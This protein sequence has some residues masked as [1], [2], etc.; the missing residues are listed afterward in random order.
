MQGML[1]YMEEAQI[2]TIAQASAFFGWDVKMAFLISTRTQAVR[3]LTAQACR[4]GRVTALSEPVTPKGHL[5]TNRINRW[6]LRLLT[7]AQHDHAESRAAL[8]LPCRK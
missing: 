3:L 8:R 2:Q 1:I 5:A 4:Q 6:V 7:H